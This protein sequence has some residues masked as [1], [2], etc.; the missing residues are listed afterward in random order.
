MTEREFQRLMMAY[1]A[2]IGRWPVA[3]QATAEKWL[4][5]N[6]KARLALGRL[7]EMDRLLLGAA[8]VISS[9]RVDGVFDALLRETALLSQQRRR[10][11]LSLPLFVW[12]QLRWAP[13]GA[14]YL[15]LFFLGCA[16]NVAVRLMAAASPLDLW[17][18]GNLSLPLG[19]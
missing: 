11:R 14:I 13:R 18:S 6:P 19:G 12:P 5:E 3:R 1:G 2:E 8:P 17:F 7:A 16:A 9:E 15:G 4:A 10:P